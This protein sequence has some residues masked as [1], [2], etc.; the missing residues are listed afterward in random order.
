[1][2]AM[3]LLI[4]HFYA[5]KIENLFYLIV[6]IIIAA[7]IYAIGLLALKDD[8]VTDV[9]DSFLNKLKLKKSDK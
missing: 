2:F 3:L 6:T 1:M 7:I 9:I 8:L 5:D 4:K